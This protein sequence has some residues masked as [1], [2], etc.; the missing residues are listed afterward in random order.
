[1][2]PLDALFGACT[3]DSRH[4]DKDPIVVYREDVPP[5]PYAEAGYL[6]AY[7]AIGE[8]PTLAMYLFKFG[9][10]ANHA[11]FAMFPLFWLAG[12]FVLLCPLILPENWELTKSEAERAE[13]LRML[14]N[15][16]VKRAR[17]CL[18]TFSALALAVITLTTIFVM[19]SS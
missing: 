1:I 16:E 12:I 13:L 9:F 6:P 18:V 14:R 15:T 7:I 17:R 8:P 5:P 2:D 19:H 10:H 3:Q 11:W 4:D